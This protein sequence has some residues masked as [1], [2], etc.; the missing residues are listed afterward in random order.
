MHVEEENHNSKSAK[1]IK[2]PAVALAQR[3]NHPHG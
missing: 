3:G 2:H 1:G